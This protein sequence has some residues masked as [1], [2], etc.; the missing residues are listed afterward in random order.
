MLET[1]GLYYFQSWK[2]EIWAEYFQSWKLE[3][4]DEV[5]TLL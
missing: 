4:W 1:Q 2:L 3:I 5:L